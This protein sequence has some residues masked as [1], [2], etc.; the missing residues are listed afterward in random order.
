M[1]GRSWFPGRFRRLRVAAP[2]NSTRGAPAAVS[3]PPTSSARQNWR[4]EKRSGPARGRPGCVGPR[5][6]R[7]FPVASLASGRPVSAGGG[8]KQVGLLRT[9]RRFGL[10]LHRVGHR[11]PHLRKPPMRAGRPP[12]TPE[13]GPGRRFGL[14]SQFQLCLVRH[15]L[16]FCS[17]R[18]GQDYETGGWTNAVQGSK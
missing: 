12:L 14:Q 5:G 2:P 18:Y 10:P 3:S 8:A 16:P 1:T 13:G 4:V 9:G 15:I 7:G 11:Q 17:H 6:G